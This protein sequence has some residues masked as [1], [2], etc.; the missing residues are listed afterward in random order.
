MST[1][2]CRLGVEEA[3]GLVERCDGLCAERSLDM[4]DVGQW[5]WLKL[6]R[7]GAKEH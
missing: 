2:L 5:C 1:A 6:E 4:V 3:F 7:F